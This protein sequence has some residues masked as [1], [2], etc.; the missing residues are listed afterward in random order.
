MNEIQ[1]K[2]AE[3][4]GAR[5]IPRSLLNTAVDGLKA[6]LARTLATATKA[7][8]ALMESH[9]E[10]GETFSMTGGSTNGSDTEDAR[11][12][13]EERTHD[14]ALRLAQDDPK[15][16]LAQRDLYRSWY[17]VAEANEKLGNYP[18]AF[19]AMQKSFEINNRLAQD[20]PHNA[21]DA[22]KL[23]A[24]YFGLGTVY[25]RMGNLSAALS[26]FKKS[27]EIF[28][29]LGQH[30][31]ESNKAQ[32]QLNLAGIYAEVGDVKG[33]LGDQLGIPRC[34]SKDAANHPEA[35]RERSAK[36][37]DSNRP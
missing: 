10:L 37:R 36:R 6:M 7:D 28:K 3:V 15:N 22:V 5:D 17:L 21:K 18:A 13:F 25:G 8:R 31:P 1:D 27:I 29:T 33:L 16:T 4:P 23:A 20:D 24:S 11:E 34:P 30:D 9:L 2:L 32:F 35:S 12:Q 19:D 26:N 14:I